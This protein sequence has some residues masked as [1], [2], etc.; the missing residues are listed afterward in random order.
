MCVNFTTCASPF[1]SVAVEKN[2]S[3]AGEAT[4]DQALVAESYS[5]AD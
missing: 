1:N 3:S 5:S 4:G 2:L